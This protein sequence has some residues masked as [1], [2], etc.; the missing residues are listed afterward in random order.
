MLDLIDFLQILNFMQN[1]EQEKVLNEII[2]RLE[3]IENAQQNS[4]NQNGT[5]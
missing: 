1:I 4:K 2:Q 3:R 5:P